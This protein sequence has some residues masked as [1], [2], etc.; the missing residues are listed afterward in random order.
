VCE[1]TIEALQSDLADQKSR[2]D[3]VQNSLERLSRLERRSEEEQKALITADGT[4]S[5]LTENIAAL[6]QQIAS[7]RKA[8]NKRDQ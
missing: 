5:V 4:V 6:E 8:A 2:L 7:L 3:R 1:A